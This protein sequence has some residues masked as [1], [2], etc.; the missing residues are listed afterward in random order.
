MRAIFLSRWVVSFIGVVLVGILLWLFAPLVA[1]G[2]SRPLESVTARVLTIVILILVWMVINLLL[3]WRAHRIDQKLS[4]DMTDSQEDAEN[5]QDHGQVDAELEAHKQRMTEALRL[6]RRSRWK[7]WLTQRYLYD[8]P[9]YLIIGPPGAGKTTMLLRSGLKFPLAEKLGNTGIRGVG[10]TRA[11]EWW[12]TDRAVF[13]DTAGRYTTQ[14]DPQQKDAQV[15]QGFLD[16][17]KKHRRHQPINGVILAISVI[18]LARLGPEGRQAHI[19]AM[20][21]RLLEMTS[22]LGTTPPV[23]V[24]FTKVDRIEGFVQFFDDLD[25][26]ARRQVWGMTAQMGKPLSIST[27]GA[28]FDG[29]IER[30]TSR[31]THRL[32]QEPDLKRRSA[33][34]G[35]PAQIASL[36]EP[37]LDMIEK[38]FAAS[39]LE[40][41][42]IFR[43][44]Y[45]TSGT[46]E[47]TPIDR[48]VASMG[49]LFGISA[50]MGTNFSGQVRTF[51]LERL[52]RHVVIAEAGVAGLDPKLARKMR[53]W[54]QALW[55]SV[56]SVCLL[57]TSLWTIS[58]VANIGE[59]NRML[60]A[61]A[62]WQNIA[63]ERD[64]RR[65]ADTDLAGVASALAILRDMPFGYHSREESVPLHR[66]WGLSQDA[67]L[68]E[69]AAWTYRRALNLV[70]LPR[71]LLRLE[72]QINSNLGRS[73]FLYEALRIYLMLG[74]QGPVNAERTIQW[75]EFDW[76]LRYPDPADEP[77][78][79]SLRD[80]LTAMLEGSLLDMPLDGQLV[81][82]ARGL[83][84]SIPLAERVY[85]RIKQSPQARAIQPWRVID[86]GGAATNRVFIRRSGKPLSDGVPGLYTYNG[87]HGIFLPGLADAAK[88]MTSESWVLGIGDGLSEEAAGEQLANLERDVLGLYLDDYAAQW[89]ELLADISV[90]PFRSLSHGAAITN[91]L[92]GP[93]SPMRNLLREVRVQTRIAEPPELIEGGTEAARSVADV[94]VEEL[95][96][97]L[98][99]RALE[100]ADIFG[101][102]ALERQQAP[103]P[104]QYIDERYQALNA[105]IG[106]P[107]EGAPP[108]EETLTSL[109]EVYR[110]LNRLS[111]S[112]GD[113]SLVSAVSQRGVDAQLEDISNTMP[114]PL[115]QW[116]LST[117]RSTAIITVGGAREQVAAAWAGK[118][119]PACQAALTNRYPFYPQ[120]GV[121]VTFDD[122]G[123]LFAPSS[124]IDQFFNENLRPFVDQTSKPW[125]WRPV[126]GV[127]IGI[128]PNA[129]RQ[130]ERA[131]EI[132]DALFAAGSR[133]PEVR[134]ELF[135]LALSDQAAKVLVEI[136]GQEVA[137]EH[138]PQNPMRVIWPGPAAT[139]RVRLVFSPI[140]GGPPVAK[141][142]EGPWAFYRLLDESQ[143]R[144]TTLADRFQVTLS[145]GPHS[146]AFEL[147]ANSIVNPFTLK[148]LSQFRCPGSL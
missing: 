134:F 98:S 65:V 147:R 46:Q 110:E 31:V 127:D 61:I 102:T 55:I 135:P 107:K 126:D 16:M 85:A 115:N 50:Q 133:I 30:L 94:A 104:G 145:V 81:A 80:G 116:L 57:I 84:Q 56:A 76:S 99:L 68:R 75:M 123:R 53:L 63:Q 4:Q 17:L 18:E 146:A 34:F 47:G 138:G 48:L 111:G 39:R 142:F 32:Q 42:P 2:E 122:F 93:N 87:F 26:P 131:A 52:L 24:V 136:N 40:S 106:D 77:V 128:S 121:D 33:L 79:L 9:W 118:V 51:F 8:M 112:G 143:L 132:R 5:S 109:Q 101:A 89:D 36:K 1:F 54:R 148:A 37:V 19:D 49:A 114:P 90:M 141:S 64:F 91:T 69:Q 27:L 140:G 95:R 66:R 117:S 14:D 15:W 88:Q 108:L 62:Q 73:D 58:T 38:I 103:L 41:P 92:S 20:R 137:Y 44:F 25:A 45:L 100:V 82:D 71:L 13:I 139:N 21:G 59:M 86:A 23:Y 144:S 130:F 10:G 22:R 83:L 70:L 29:L 74:R 7:S 12:F 43:G 60:S 3:S 105:F 72:D 125:Q 78:R 35:F 97:R 129:L 113:V 11:C 124:D 6:L 28:A 67:T 120:S 96:S 119:G